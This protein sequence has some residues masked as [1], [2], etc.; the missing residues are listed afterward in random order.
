MFLAPG[1]ASGETRAGT[2]PLPACLGSRRVGACTLWDT[3]FGHPASVCPGVAKTLARRAQARGSRRWPRGV[4]EPASAKTAARTHEPKRSRLTCG[5]VGSRGVGA[6]TLWDTFFGH[7]A[8]VCPGVAKTLARRVQARGSLRWQRGAEKSASAKTAARTHGPKRSRL[9]WGQVGSRG[10]GACT[11]W[12]TFF[13][14]PASVYP[15]VAKTLARRAQARGSL[16]WP[17]GV[18]ESASAK[19]AARTHGLKRSRPASGQVG[20]RGVGACTLWDTFFGHPASVYP[21]VAKTLA[22]RAQ[23]SG[24][25]RWAG[26]AGRNGIRGHRCLG[27][28]QG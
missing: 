18:E 7:P 13:G 12:D 28:E 16:R 15:G 2:L 10:V 6:C 22:R 9:A 25:T 17:R 27:G 3:S 19:T 26:G 4:E 14:H 20:S 24:F 8:S 1:S 21:G 11:L 23:A 5:Q